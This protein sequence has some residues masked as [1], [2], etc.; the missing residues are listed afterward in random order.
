MFGK[1]FAKESD[2]FKCF[3]KHIHV[4]KQGAEVFTQLIASENKTQLIEE[5]RDLEHQADHITRKCVEMIHTTF[6][7]PFDQNDIYQLIS[8]MD[9]I[10]DLIQDASECIILY[11]LSVIP[12]GIHQLSHVLKLIIAELERT[13][14]AFCHHQKL[15]ILREKF[16]TIHRLENDGDAVMRQAL[17]ALFDEEKD[18][19]TVI[20]WKEVYENLED[21][22][23]TCEDVANIIEGIM[24]ET[25]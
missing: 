22:I 3:E 4:T 15:T 23:D 24:L 20:K 10:I 1:F 13:L 18:P 5:I 7:T 21:A 9:D 12:P 2:F 8:R 19:L 11:R 17:G 16:S 14:I 6:I 25:F